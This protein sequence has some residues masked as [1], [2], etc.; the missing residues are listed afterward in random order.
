MELAQ[1]KNMTHRAIIKNINEGIDRN[2]IQKRYG[3]SKPT[4]YRVRK[5]YE[6]ALCDIKDTD[7]VPEDVKDYGTNL[8]AKGKAISLKIANALLRKN[9]AGASLSQLTTSMVN[10]NQMVRLEEGKS[11]ENIAHNVLHNLGDAE[12]TLIRESIAHFKKEMVG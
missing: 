6:D 4:F 9:F 11:T 12:L 2:T 8:V 5:Q 3:I 10:V 7:I 1:I